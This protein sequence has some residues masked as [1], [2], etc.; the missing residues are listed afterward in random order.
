MSDDT[1]TTPEGPEGASGDEVK[2]VDRGA[3]RTAADSKRNKKIAIIGGIVAVLVI[4]GGA[5]AWALTGSEEA[6][7]TTTTTTTTAAAPTTTVPLPVGPVAPLTGVQLALDD[8]AGAALLNRPALVAKVDNAVEAMPQIGLEFADMVIEIQVEGISRYMSVFHSKDVQQIGPIRS[9]RTSDPD[10]FAMFVRPLVAWSGGNKN[11]TQIM[12]ETPWIQ[13][14]TP[15]QA[16]NAYS[17][18]SAKSA[19]HNLVLDV[20]TIYSYADQPPA[21]PVPLFGYLAPGQD[22]GGLPVAAF[23]LQVGSSP[24]AFV[25]DGIAGNWPRFANGR[26]HLDENGNQLAPTNVVMLET[27]YVPSEADSRSPEAVTVGSGVAWVFTQGRIIG[28]TWQRDAPEQPWRL[29]SADG[30]P[31]LLTPGTT[32]VELSQTGVQPLVL[33]EVGTAALNAL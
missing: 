26:R 33:D 18:T 21:V 23:S 20:P 9:A 27:P 15:T 14:L 10:L 28:G 12:D 8:A 31:I 24:S 5:L 7:P 17:R 19:P 16:P 4:G 32:W 22:P 30:Q 13:S 3:T 11:V 6:A 2:A 25:W 1:P 29:T